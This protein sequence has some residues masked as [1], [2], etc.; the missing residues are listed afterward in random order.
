MGGNI[1]FTSQSTMGFFTIDTD[2]MQFTD[3]WVSNGMYD[4]PMSLSGTPP[5]PVSDMGYF[6]SPGDIVFVD[7]VANSF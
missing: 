2:S 1:S 7:K 3:S 6:T 5:N 4:S